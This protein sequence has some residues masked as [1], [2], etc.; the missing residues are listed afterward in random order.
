MLWCLA[1]TL[2]MPWFNHSRGYR[3]MGEAIN[4]ALAPYAGECVASGKLPDP[5]RS[6]L[7]YYA[8][9]RPVP[10]RS[11]FVSSCRLLL[12][13]ADHRTGKPSE[14]EDKEPTWTFQRVGRK[15]FEALYLYTRPDHG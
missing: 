5:I 1:I 13:Y 15:Y 12:I 3:S 4:G 8:D 14:I 6:M 10:V 2:L 11:G 7:D 9:L